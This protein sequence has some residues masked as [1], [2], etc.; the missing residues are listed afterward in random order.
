MK[1][2]RIP[3]L[4]LL[5]VLGLS[6]PNV[7]AVDPPSAVEIGQPAGLAIE[8]GRIELIN[9]RTQ[10]QLLVTG[11]YSGDEV[12]DLTAAATFASSNP[13]VAKVEGSV[14]LPVGNGEAVVTATVAGQTASVPVLVKNIEAPAPVSFKNETQMALTKAGCNMGACHGSPSGKGGFRLSLRAYDP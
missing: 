9:K 3:Q 6:S 5:A 1:F 13:A 12:R 11:K 4:M 10:Q 14:V 2:V 8:P 7:W